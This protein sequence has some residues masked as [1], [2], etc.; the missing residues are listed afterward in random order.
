MV[1][2]RGDFELEPS[3]EIKVSLFM[4]QGF[5]SFHCMLSSMSDSISL[6]SSVATGSGM[7][8]RQADAKL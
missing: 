1:S 8:D 4:A 5:L 3:S 7:K 6:L 2:V